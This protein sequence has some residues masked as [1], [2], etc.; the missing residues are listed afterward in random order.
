MDV[1]M[2]TDLRAGALVRPLMRAQLDLLG[3]AW[4]EHKAWTY[5]TFIIRGDTDKIGQLLRWI[6]A[7]GL[8]RDRD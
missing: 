3:I 5:S 7:S 4:I 6:K 1:P 8:D 2:T